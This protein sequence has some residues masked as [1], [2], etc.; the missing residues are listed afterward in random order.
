MLFNTVATSLA[1]PTE[2]VDNLIEAGQ[3]LLRRSP[4]F[5]DLVDHMRSLD[6]KDRTNTAANKR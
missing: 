5:Q 6:K 2:E 4:E 3:R 1:L